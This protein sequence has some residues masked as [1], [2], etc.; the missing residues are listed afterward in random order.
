MD[1]RMLPPAQAARYLGVTVGWLAKRRVY[2]DGPPY[3]KLLGRVLYD[4]IDLDT[5]I[6]QNKRHS[7]S[8]RHQQAK[9]A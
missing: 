1:K 7:T 5:L 4:R 2:G 8:D 6:E 9:S 3:T